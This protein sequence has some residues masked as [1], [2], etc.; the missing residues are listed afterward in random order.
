MRTKAKGRFDTREELEHR[1][2]FFANT[3]NLTVSQIARNV[4]VS[5][6]TVTSIL[7]DAKTKK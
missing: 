3:T 6:P 7:K 1:V 2:M 5:A 4:G